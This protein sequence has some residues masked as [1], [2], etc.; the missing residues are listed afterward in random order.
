MD[1]KEWLNATDPAPMLMFLK[2]KVSERKVR[3]FAVACCRRIWHLVVDERSRQA[4]IR[5]EM[6]A[7]A[8]TND[9]RHAI[10]SIR[11]QAREAEHACGRKLASR[12]VRAS[13]GRSGVYA[14]AAA[15]HLAALAHG[16]LQQEGVTAERNRQASLLRDIVA[17]PFATSRPI[18]PAV[19]RWN[20]GTV[21]RI[22]TGIYEERAFERLPVLADALLDAGCDDEPLLSHLRDGGPH[23]LGC[24]A[25]DLMLV[26]E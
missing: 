6:F 19:L 2:R 8:R 11:R 3:L 4:I 14:A 22:A 12:A 9:D 23:A 7:D 17:N 13:V 10:K 25:L 26:K 5:V 21:L 18:D 16:D 24:W 15:S 1:E 20:D